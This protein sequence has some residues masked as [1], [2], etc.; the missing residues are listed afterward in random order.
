MQVYECLLLHDGTSLHA[1]C[2]HIKCCSMGT[3]WIDWLSK[4]WQ[5]S[6]G[7]KQQLF[8]GKTCLAMPQCEAMS[9]HIFLLCT[10]VVGGL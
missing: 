9:F 2:V 7:S 4:G 6:S 10:G 3:V 1:V 5:L 8:E